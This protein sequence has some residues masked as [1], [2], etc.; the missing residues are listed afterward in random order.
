MVRQR[1]RTYLPSVVLGIVCGFMAPNRSWAGDAQDAK[2]AFGTAS[3]FFQAEEYQAALPLFQK[4]YELSGQRPATIFGL[5]QCERSLKQYVKAMSHFREYLATGPNNAAD[6][7]E[8]IGLLEELITVQGD[9]LAKK[10]ADAAE[11]AAVASKAAAAEAQADRLRKASAEQAAR[12]LAETRVE[13]SRKKSEAAAGAQDSE[14]SEEDNMD[15]AASNFAVPA[16][17][18]PAP[19]PAAPRAGLQP[20]LTGPAPISAEH[21]QEGGVFSSPWF[22]TVA[23]VVV[24]G[25]AVASGV[26]LSG[27]GPEDVYGGSTG[28]VLGN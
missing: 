17:P 3:R 13:A 26:L 8:T 2:K 21:V 20:D 18:P 15:S 10:Q 19:T 27:G 6:V 28:V 24:V 14:T 25:G 11:K 9:A 7:T 1:L 12:A 4:A 16:A 22:W 23:S 5:A